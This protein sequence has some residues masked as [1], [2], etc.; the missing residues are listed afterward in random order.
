MIAPLFCPQSLDNLKEN[1]KYYSNTN[2][3]KASILVDKEFDFII[4]DIWL[5][6]GNAS[7]GLRNQI[8]MLK[9]SRECHFYYG[10]EYG[11]STPAYI[12]ETPSNVFTIYTNSS[13]KL[14]I[15]GCWV[16]KF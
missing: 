2:E 9:N 6:S 10:H 5:K 12:R 11:G 8:L 14:E 13:I 15:K 16:I 3:D 7:T 4:F 1:G